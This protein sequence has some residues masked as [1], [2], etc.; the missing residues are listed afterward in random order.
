MSSVE[1]QNK[2]FKEGVQ[3]SKVFTSED[4]TSS[5]ALITS[6]GDAKKKS[7]N[8]ATSRT[9][10]ATN[11][12]LGLELCYPKPF[13]TIFIS[14]MLGLSGLMGILL[15]FASP[16]AS[17]QYLAALPFYAFWSYWLFCIDYACGLRYNSSPPVKALTIILISLCTFIFIP[18][19]GDLYFQPLIDP[20]FYI[21]L[22]GLAYIPFRIGMFLEQKANT[23]KKTLAYVLA[24]GSIGLP[25]LAVFL[26]DLT[27]CDRAIVPAL[28]WLLSQ[29]SWISYVV[30]KL[31]GEFDV[32]SQS[33]RS[34]KTQV[35]AGKN[36]V[37]RYRAFPELERWFEQ[38]FNSDRM[39]KGRSALIMW[40]GA[41]P[42]LLSSIIGLSTIMP[43]LTPTNSVGAAAQ[44]AAASATGYGHSELA[45]FLALAVLL[46]LNLALFMQ[47][48]L[49]YPT[50]LSIGE[51]GI[52]F[53]WRR[54]F[55]KLDGSLVAWS[56]LRNIFMQR[57]ENQSS[58]AFGSLCFQDDHGKVAKVRLQCLDSFDDKE[59]LLNAI[60]T[61]APKVSKE[62]SVIE[63]LQPPSGYSYTELWLQALSAPPKRDRFK[64]LVADAHLKDN[65]YRILGSLGA[66]GQGFAY[67][68]EDCA[69]HTEVVLKEFILPVYVDV[70]VRKSALEQF[71]NEARI[72]S[73]LQHPQVVHLQDYFVEDHRAYLVL[74]HI[75]GASLKEIVEH[76]GPLDQ[77]EVVKLAFQMCDIL[78]YL[79]NQAPPVV[80][81]DFAPDNLLLGSDGV[82]KLIDFNVAE[83]NDSATT[84]GTVVGKPAY[85][86]P[87]QFRGAPTSQSDVYSMGA[88]LYFLLTGQEPEPISV[89][90]AIEVNAGIDFALDQIIVN[91]TQLE[92]KDRFANIAVLKEAL[93]KVSF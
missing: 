72:L 78:S 87:E 10:I 37:M 62:A 86:P 16:S 92:E 4:K 2:P 9:S 79:H 55:F 49:K 81:R 46:A 3:T 35:H 22:L 8:I 66:G 64:P 26:Q 27:T 61:W 30:N 31:S 63:S 57:P 54:K 48:C 88:T 73:R 77:K 43:M 45:S 11:E 68:A 7:Q 74:E 85:L 32:S 34:K 42:L 1:P 39:L 70:R 36:I 69:Q 84:T 90:H 29:F 15:R 53:I 33:S 14:I 91:A 58:S 12:N 44:A 28:A 56:S 80:H 75:D 50:H 18:F 65:R 71:E 59:L 51:K 19:Y 89:S 23:A 20:F 21:W 76:K 17:S 82:L 38:K 6:A 93:E 67:L 24:G 60:N 41:P 40:F 47:C 25:L 52:R 13:I 83:S 5:G